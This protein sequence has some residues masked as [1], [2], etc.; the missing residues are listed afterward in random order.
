MKMTKS[1]ISDFVRLNNEKALQYRKDGFCESAYMQSVLQLL[2]G[3]LLRHFTNPN[4][5]L[6][7]LSKSL[8]GLKAAHDDFREIQT[9]MQ[10]F[11]DT[12]DE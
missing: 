6:E 1:R 11:S 9:V 4:G 7:W 3:F 12:E 5:A 8:E 10:E 2:N